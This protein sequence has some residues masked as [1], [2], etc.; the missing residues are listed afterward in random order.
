MPTLRGVRYDVCLAWVSQAATNNPLS[1]R[2]RGGVRG[3]PL[4]RPSG[5]FSQR[6][7]GS[8]GLVEQLTA[9]QHTTDLAGAGADLVELGV[10]Q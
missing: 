9:D 8:L 3:K 10:A 6:E 7:K 4:I 1:L 5:T 2:E